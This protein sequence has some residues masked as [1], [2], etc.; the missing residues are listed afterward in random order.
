[1][2]CNQSHATHRCMFTRK[3]RDGQIK[4]PPNFCWSHCGRVYDL[5][6]K[7]QCYIITTKNIKKLNLTCGKPN[8][9]N[10][11]FLLCPIEGCK[12]GCEKFWHKQADKKVVVNLLPVE[13]VDLDN[14]IIDID[15]EDLNEKLEISDGVA[16]NQ[17]FIPT[18]AIKNEDNP[19][20]TYNFAKTF[21]RLEK[22]NAMLPDS[23]ETTPVLILFDGGSGKTVGN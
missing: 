1:M 8:H 3:L 17:F 2:L 15:Y 14:E 6:H 4:A 20:V 9:G 19:I 18:L 10:K 13:D 11:H 12:K 5:C 7:K 22:V 21:F 23:N 16:F